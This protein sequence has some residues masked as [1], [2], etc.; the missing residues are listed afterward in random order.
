MQPSRILKAHEARNLGSRVVFNYE[1]IRKRC[2][3]SI[4]QAQRRAK[5]ILDDVAQEAEEIRR[6]AHASGLLAGREA[7]ARDVE[8]EIERRARELA[9][10]ISSEKLQTTLPAMTAA[11]A[12]LDRERDRWLADWEAFGVRLSA[13]IAEKILRRHLDIHPE[14]VAG[15]L[16]ETLRLAAG[17]TS[18]ALR[19]HPDDVQFLG[20]HPAEMARS[21][22]SCAEVAIV[23]DTRT[24]RGGCVIE[25]RHG[26]IDAQIETQLERIVDELLQS[27]ASQPG[28]RNS[29]TS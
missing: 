26:V 24:T 23:P 8:G 18:I 1:D 25:S 5:E 7:A 11:A 15:M 14:A 6:C 10:K 20:D 13:L 28:E 27:E 16:A 2:D 12:A 21:M 3:E 9:E 19:L 4:E 22:A 17:N 29:S